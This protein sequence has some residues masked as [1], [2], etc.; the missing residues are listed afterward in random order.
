ME[1]QEVRGNFSTLTNIHKD[2]KEGGIEEEVEERK[3]DEGMMKEVNG[4]CR[5][6]EA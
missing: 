4:L 2:T 6:L 1:H 3:T 5:C